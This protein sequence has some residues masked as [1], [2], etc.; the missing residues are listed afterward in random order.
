[1]AHEEKLNLEMKSLQNVVYNY[2]DK[3]LDKLNI[4]NQLFTQ[5]KEL[6]NFVI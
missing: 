4:D 1:M 6:L 2:I 5:M 3:D